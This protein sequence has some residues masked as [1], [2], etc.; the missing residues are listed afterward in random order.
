MARQ[1]QW[2]PRVRVGRG[3]EYVRIQHN[4]RRRYVTLGPVG[5]EAARRAYARI[6][7]EAAAGGAPALPAGPL[8]CSVAEA[9]ARYLELWADRD[10]RPYCL[11]KRALAGVLALY[12]GRPLGEF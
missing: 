5:S 4:G 6:L 11:R 9:A 7:A 12:A 8:G 1:S 10:R 2:P 3:V